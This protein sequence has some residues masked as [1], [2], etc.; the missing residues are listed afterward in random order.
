[1]NPS[2]RAA[3]APRTVVLVLA[4]MLTALVAI[5]LARVAYGL[6]LA[7]MQ[8][9]LGLSLAQAGNLGTLTALGYLL[10]VLP[11]GVAAARWGT[12]NAVL[13]GLLIIALGFV[14]L[15]AASNYALVAA[16]MLLLGVGTAGCFAPM[17]SLIATWFPLRRGLMIGWMTTGIG[18]G[19]FLAGLLVPQLMRLFGAHGWRQAWGLFA[20]IA[21]AVFLLV[22]LGVRDPPA[23]QAAGKTPA[24]AADKWRIYRHP[25]I[26]TVGLTYGVLGAVYIVQALFMVSFAQASGIDGAVAGALFSMAGLLSVAA[27]PLWGWLSDRW[28]R[29]SVLLLSMA[30]VTAA[31][32]LPLLAQALPVFF[33]HFLLTGCAFQGAFTMVQTISTDQVAPRHIPIAVSYVTLFFAGGQFLGPAAGSWLIG[34]GGFKA[35]LAFAWTLLLLGLILAQRM[36]RFPAQPAVS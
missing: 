34:V 36:R 20:L 21:A 12:R 28:N 9:D 29:A 7:P 3:D 35:A 6:L 10:F 2:K 11:G 8:V 25:R 23:L 15:A 31:M 16:L 4:A 17:L 26:I 22:L 24:A 19:M 33:V 18:G 32:A 30:L 14:G 27:G 5:V 1:M 13:G